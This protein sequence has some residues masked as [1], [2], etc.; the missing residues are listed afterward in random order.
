M[1]FSC[2]VDVEVGVIPVRW[3]GELRIQSQWHMDM[4]SS[5]DLVRAMRA[6]SPVK[7]HTL[8]KPTPPEPKNNVRVLAPKPLRFRS[9]S[10]Q[11]FKNR[12][13]DEVAEEASTEAPSV[14]FLEA[15]PEEFSRLGAEFT[16]RDWWF[17]RFVCFR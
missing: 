4:A 17:L 11:E 13:G 7:P 9:G 1:L 6:T 14:D 3:E 12:H 16:T 2:G 5:R 15:C 10:V 8:L